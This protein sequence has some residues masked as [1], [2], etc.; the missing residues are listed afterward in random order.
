MNVLP[1]FHRS[2]V[3]VGA[4][5]IHSK[6]IKLSYVHVISFAVDDG[7]VCDVLHILLDCNFVSGLRTLK[8]KNFFRNLVFFEPECSS[9]CCCS[10]LSKWVR[11][12]M[13]YFSMFHGAQQS[14]Q[15][16]TQDL[17]TRMSADET[18]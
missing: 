4:E 14:L 16:F 18:R 17:S 5:N 10:G 1:S 11:Q 8:P 12:K 15:Q 9:V 6:F 3:Q 13:Q 2:T 7:C